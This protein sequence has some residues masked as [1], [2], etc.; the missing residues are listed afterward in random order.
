MNGHEARVHVDMMKAALKEADYPTF[1]AL[2]KQ[3]SDDHF[4]A[5][6]VIAYILGHDDGAR[7][8]VREAVQRALSKPQTQKRLGRA[9]AV[10]AG[11]GQSLYQ[12]PGQEA[13]P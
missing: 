11:A 13:N 10:G 4:Q 1:H 5:A 2:V 9:G 6:V 7:E 3:V 12:A 8:T